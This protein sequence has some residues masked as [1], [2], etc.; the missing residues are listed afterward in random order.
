[1]H[2]NEMGRMLKIAFFFFHFFFQQNHL[3]TFKVLHTSHSTLDRTCSDSVVSLRCR[4]STSDL[5]NVSDNGSGTPVVTA[6]HRRRGSSKVSFLENISDLI[7]SKAFTHH[8]MV[9]LI[10]EFYA[11]ISFRIKNFHLLSSLFYVK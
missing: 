6:H 5:T 10:N 8:F 11:P 7:S 9:S 1:M 4:K 3:S 2:A